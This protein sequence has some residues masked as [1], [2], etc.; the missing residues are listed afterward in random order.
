MSS[1][2]SGVSPSNSYK[3]GPGNSEDL[4]SNDVDAETDQKAG[5]DTEEDQIEKGI[6]T[7]A[8]AAHHGGVQEARDPF[9]GW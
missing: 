3:V 8:G 6:E 4:M 9:E 7:E 2:A 1:E 5:M